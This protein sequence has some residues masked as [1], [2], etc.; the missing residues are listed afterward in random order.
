M[1]KKEKSRWSTN[2]III[3]TLSCVCVLMVFVLLFMGEVIGRNQK[4]NSSIYPYS[5]VYYT[6]DYEFQ[7]IKLGMSDGNETFMERYV[8]KDV[9]EEIYISFLYADPD[10]SM[11]DALEAFQKDGDYTFEVTENVTFGSGDYRATLISYTDKTGIVPVEVKYY[12]MPEREL[13]ITTCTDQ[14]HRADIEKMLKS[15][16]LR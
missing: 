6:G 7:R 2:K 16:E 4:L 10:E 3:V 11:E 9:S 12:Y 5:M 15:V 1:D 8:A 13:M 14:A